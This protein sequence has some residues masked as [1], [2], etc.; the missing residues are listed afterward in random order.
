MSQVQILYPVAAMLLLTCVV[1]VF[2]LGERI[3]GMKQRKLHPK[4]M[5]SSSQMAATLQNTR[6]ADHYKNLFEMPVF[7]YALCVALLATE[8]AGPGIVLMAWIYVALRVAHSVI[9]IGYNKIR[10]RL[11][12][13][14]ASTTLLV[15]MWAAFIAQLAL[16]GA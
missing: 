11:A 2:M 1:M 3:A 15:M 9:H 14:V 8:M 5:P 13:F 16:R 6:A 7:F 4:T 12:V 10:H